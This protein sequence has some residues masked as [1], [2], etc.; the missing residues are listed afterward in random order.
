ML[1][2]NALLLPGILSL[3]YDKIGL[4]SGA[5]NPIYFHF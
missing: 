1:F 5:D 3:I 2:V 4:L